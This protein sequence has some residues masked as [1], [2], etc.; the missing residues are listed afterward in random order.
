MPRRSI[1]VRLSTAKK[2]VFYYDIWANIHYGYVGKAAGFSENDLLTGAALEQA[3]AHP[4]QTGDDLSDRASIQ[5][6]IR[7]YREGSRVSEEDVL[8]ELYIH[9]SELN[10]ARVED[11]KI[12]E[13][14]R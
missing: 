2:V 12:K 6:G 9:K 4:G 10:K 7:L 13:V 5:I 14:Y 3:V 1:S 11:G 8:R